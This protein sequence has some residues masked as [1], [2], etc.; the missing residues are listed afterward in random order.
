MASSVPKSTGSEVSVPSYFRCARST[1]RMRC[2]GT[3]CR[4][5]SPAAALPSR[6]TASRAC[7][8]DDSASGSSTVV[9]RMAVWSASPMP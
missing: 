9:S 5:S 6:A 7:A 2:A 8:I 3:P 4:S 1:R